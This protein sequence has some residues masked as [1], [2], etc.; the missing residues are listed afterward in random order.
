MSL[1]PRA[2]ARWV[3]FSSGVH[4]STYSALLAA[5]AINTSLAGR[6]DEDLCFAEFEMRYRVGLEYG[7]LGLTCGFTV[8]D[9]IMLRSGTRW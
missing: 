1:L 4:L 2:R 6:V 8:I 5:R 3:V 9:A 7:I